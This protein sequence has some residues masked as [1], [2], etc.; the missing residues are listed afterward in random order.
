MYVGKP[1]HLSSSQ[2]TMSSILPSH[3]GPSNQSRN[4]DHNY[5]TSYASYVNRG[6]HASGGI[7]NITPQTPSNPLGVSRLFSMLSNL[8]INERNSRNVILPVLLSTLPRA[9]ILP[10]VPSPHDFALFK[11]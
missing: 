4:I 11:S 8:K 9:S 6:Y 5:E 2:T 1:I 3:G 10:D 7:I